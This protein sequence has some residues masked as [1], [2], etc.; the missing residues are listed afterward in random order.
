MLY[1]TGLTLTPKTQCFK[2]LFRLTHAMRCY[3]SLLHRPDLFSHIIIERMTLVDKLLTPM[4]V[5]KS[6]AERRD[7][8]TMFGFVFR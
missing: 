1:S 4:V 8:T 2:I 7:G 3:L 5:P 6:V